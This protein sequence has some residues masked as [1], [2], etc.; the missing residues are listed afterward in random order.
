MDD[1]HRKTRT[2]F[3]RD[4]AAGS[5]VSAGYDELG[6]LEIGGKYL[7]AMP[8]IDCDYE[9]CTGWQMVAPYAAPDVALRILAALEPA[10]G[11][12]DGWNA[13]LEAER[14][15]HTATLKDA[16]DECARAEA[17]EADLMIAQGQIADAQSYLAERD[18]LKAENERFRETNR[19]VQR[20][21]QLLEGWWQ[22]R[23][24][25]A[26]NERSMYLGFICRDKPELRAVEE[27]AY[28][29]GYRDGHDDRF[30]IPKRRAKARAALQE[31]RT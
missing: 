28:Q 12:I 21:L 6:F 17:A 20:R 31:Q 2:Q 3:V 15:S 5:G 26:R 22:R 27:A 9:G 7:L 23:V 19:R 18:A 4:Y 11:Y 24:E 16:Q 8:C 14:A 1:K 29:R 10:P 25:R 13:A 30:V